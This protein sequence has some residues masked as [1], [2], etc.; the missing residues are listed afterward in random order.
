MSGVEA[1]A[2]RLSAKAST[3]LQKHYLAVY[4]YKKGNLMPFFKLEERLF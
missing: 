2:G 4:S 3:L 1:L